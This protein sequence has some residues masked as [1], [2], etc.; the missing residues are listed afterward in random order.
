MA[1]EQK[2]KL[3]NRNGVWVCL[4]R[5]NPLTSTNNIEIILKAF[6]TFYRLIS[7]TAHLRSMSG[8]AKEKMCHSIK[9]TWGIISLKLLLMYKTVV[10]SQA[11]KYQ[12]SR[13]AYTQGVHI[14]I[15]LHNTVIGVN[16]RNTSFKYT[17]IFGPICEREPN[18]PR[19]LLA[20]A[21]LH[22]L[23]GLYSKYSFHRWILNLHTPD[24]AAPAP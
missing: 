12:I 23:W 11:H 16:T 20:A 10:C 8:R 14:G 18:L 15:F 17:Y 19:D 22:P 1:R 2:V 4:I 6:H 7:Q 9:N 24:W 3:W 5:Y 13:W 21:L